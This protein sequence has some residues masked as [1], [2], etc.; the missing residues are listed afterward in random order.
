MR[1]NC[2]AIRR[3]CSASGGAPKE[4]DRRDLRGAA[5]QE[6]FRP[7]R[8]CAGILHLSQFGSQFAGPQSQTHAFAANHSCEVRHNGQTV[9]LKKT[10]IEWKAALST[11]MPVEM[12]FSV[13]GQRIITHAHLRLLQRF[14]PSSWAE[15]IPGTPL[16]RVHHGS[17]FL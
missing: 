13:L 15:T 7:G 9:L 17:L 12:A 6:I 11:C 10:G 4:R 14:A 5:A 1:R 2:D 3:T 8:F 16:A